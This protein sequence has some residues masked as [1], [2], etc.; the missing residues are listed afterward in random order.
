M[1]TI[2]LPNAARAVS[3]DRNASSRGRL[4]HL[5][6]A[7][8]TQR[9]HQAERMANAHLGA[10]SDAQLTHLGLST[11]EIAAVRAGRRIGDVLGTRR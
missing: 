3:A 7:F 4:R 1:S 11:P 8:I 10:M 5:F 6:D 2:A 9:M